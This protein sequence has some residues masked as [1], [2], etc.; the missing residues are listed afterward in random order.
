MTK[1][2]R[3][4]IVWQKSYKLSLL[5]YEQTSRF[6]KSE[7]YSLTSQ[8]RRAVVSIPSNIAE[9]YCRYSKKE[10]IQFLQI[11]YGSG[12]ELE[13]QVLLAKDLKYISEK[14]YYEMS[15]LLLEVMKMLN[16]LIAKVRSSI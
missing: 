2:Y 13:T 8:V 14:D 15:D 7:I 4:L 6:P 5:I 1:T 11:A 16:S 10:Y 12:A 3:E 9:G